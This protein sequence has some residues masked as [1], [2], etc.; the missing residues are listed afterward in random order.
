MI[1]VSNTIRIPVSGMDEYN[2]IS[3]K[4]DSYKLDKVSSNWDKVRVLSI[5]DDP[6]DWVWYS[7]KEENISYEEWFL[8]LHAS[9]KNMFERFYY[10]L[11]KQFPDKEIDVVA[12]DDASWCM[13]VLTLKLLNWRAL[14]DNY[15]EYSYYEDENELSN[16]EKSEIENNLID[17]TPKNEKRIVDQIQQQKKILSKHEYITIE[18]IP[19]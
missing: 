15:K 8:V 1:Y 11:S 12:V 16:D 14:V 19:F 6:Y 7:S 4:I 10:T 5:V 9:V 18:D 3:N 13:W 2:E 17:N